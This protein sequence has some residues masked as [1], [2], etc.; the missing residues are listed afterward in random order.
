VDHGEERGELLAR[1]RAHLVVVV[2]HALAMRQR[3]PGARVMADLALTDGDGETRA[4]RV[5]DVAHR[6][7]R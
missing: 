4:Q 1:E 3:R 5:E 7:V 6:G 2:A